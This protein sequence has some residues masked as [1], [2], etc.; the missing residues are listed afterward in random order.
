MAHRISVIAGQLISKPC[1]AAGEISGFESPTGMVYPPNTSV[2]LKGNL[3]PVQQEVDGPLVPVLGSLPA[4]LNGKFVRNGPNPYL[5]RFGKPYHEFEGDAMMHA[6]DLQNG[7]GSYSNRW[8]QTKR[9]A[10]DK[11]KGKLSRAMEY[12]G[13]DGVSMGTANTAFV[14]HAKQLLALYETDRPYVISAP[15]L[16]T[17][18]PLTQ[19]NAL[20]HNMT[21]HPKVCPKTGE[22]VY[23]G[24]SLMEPK[25]MYGVADAQGSRTCRLEV[26]TRGNR[27][28]MMHDMAITEHY[29]ILMEFPLY[30]DMSL[31]VKGAMPFVLD[32]SCPAM[33]GI[34]PRHANSVDQIRWFKGK[35]AMMFHCANAWEE[36][37]K[38]KL[39]GCPAAEFS[40]DYQKSSASR[41]YEWVFD[42]DTGLTQERELDDTWVEFPII[43]PQYLGSRNRFIFASRFTGGSPPFHSIDGCV[44]YD[45]ET[46]KMLR[47]NFLDGRWG[48][49]CVFVPR[50][51]AQ[52][53]DDGYLLTYTYN[54]KDS[55]TELYVIDARTMAP[56]PLA[57]LRTPQRVPFGF[58][59]I[60]LSRKDVD[61]QKL[62]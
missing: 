60:W 6:V 23:F 33:F 24:Y 15:S 13:R 31:A 9:L 40:F 35:L 4:D 22:L 34:L 27:P 47:H 26:P 46:G 38:V 29:S 45:V 12:M 19:G 57:V 25:I 50:A 10:M 62:P 28:V 39:I 48:G 58:H 43:H 7:I 21:A 54:P 61:D 3:E 5:S 8:V 32:R 14:Y 53:E 42:M 44:K 49:E 30:F 52:S 56:T 11:K 20:D 2:T 59:G 51:A 18:G 37:S 16:E 55:S 36:G 41:L 1:A 17:I